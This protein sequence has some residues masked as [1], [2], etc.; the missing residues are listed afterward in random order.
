[1]YGRIMLCAE[2]TIAYAIQRPH[3]RL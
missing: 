3:Q 2:S 1:M